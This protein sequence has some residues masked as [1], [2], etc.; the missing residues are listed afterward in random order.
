MRLIVSALGI[1]AIRANARLL[2]ARLELVGPGATIA[3]ARRRA[4]AHDWAA[5][6]RRAGC[7]EARR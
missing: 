6:A 1:T 7:A 2:L 4:A 5:Q 3:A